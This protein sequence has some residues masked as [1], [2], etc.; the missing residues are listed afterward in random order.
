MDFPHLRQNLIKLCFVNALSFVAVVFFAAQTA[1]AAVLNVP[2]ARFATVQSAVD[3]AAPGD[4]IVLQAGVTFNESIV[5]RY[6]TGSDYITIQSSAINALPP[7]GHRVNP[8]FAPLMP[9]IK[10][11]GYGSAAM[12]TEITPNGASHHYRLI[13]LELAQNDANQMT[14]GLLLLG[15]GGS[16]QDT[17]DKVAHDFEVDRCYIHGNT[18]GEVRRGVALNS[19]HT[20]ITNSYIVDVHQVGYDTQA[21]CGWNGPGDYKIINNYLEGAAENIMFGG[22]DSPIPNL[23]PSDIVV[24]HNYL[25]K[26]LAWRD[27]ARKWTTKNLFELKNARRVT[28]D[29]NVFENDWGYA[30]GG[31]QNGTGILFTVRND[32]GR[33][34]WSAVQDVTFTNNIVRRVGTGI[35]I[36][37]SD[38]GHQS[39]TTKN[40]VIDNNLFD[41]IGDDAVKGNGDVLQLT[42]GET[43][44]RAAQNVTFTNNTAIHK[45]MLVRAEDGT[46]IINFRIEGNIAKEHILKE[47]T[48][49]VEAL[50]RIGGD[51]WTFNKNAMY[52]S[53]GYGYWST[54]YPNAGAN[55]NKYLTSA[56]DFGFVNQAA[57]NFRVAPTSALR[58]QGLNGKDVGADFHRF[59][60]ALTASDF[61]SDGKTDAVVWRPQD[62]VWYSAMSGD[63]ATVRA[64]QFGMAGDIPVAADYD[65]DGQTD[66]AVFRPSTGVW[67]IWQSGD[68]KMRS[69][70]FGLSGDVPTVGDFDGDG[71]ADIAVF[72]A[73]KGTAG[74]W[75]VWQSS[76]NSMTV[77]QWGIGGDVPAVGDFDG[78]GKTDVAV[79]R[80]SNGSWYIVNSFDNR[81]SAFQFGANGDIPTVGDYNGDGR[82]EIAVWRPAN[83]TW[84]TRRA[85]GNFDALQWGANGDVPTMGDFD[86]DGKTDQAVFRPS[87]GN[88][89]IVNSRTGTTTATNFGHV[90]DKPAVSA[91]Q[92]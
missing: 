5:L 79:F 41:A 86:G 78:D 34:P 89:Y 90:G 65:G 11:V 63:K 92:F 27:R 8:S 85:D 75:Y 32:E 71:K 15:S 22:S 40:I 24:R 43:P 10:P 6:K 19:F 33:A 84:Y 9:K 57:G 64:F 29:R 18:E 14:Y 88:W 81:I 31:S 23:V 26:P 91:A 13:G 58:N 55:Q 4:T 7:A 2:S 54:Q 47:G 30:L 20:S 60:A 77:K 59:N 61:D 39:E 48:A 72:R 53:A 51:S 35:N 76:T 52:I 49:G 25:Y 56:G 73:S 62:G 44:E 16:D 37:G 83:G 46:K 80:P 17:L 42:G 68:S 21:I 28:I 50:N 82:A 66:Y 87:N 69:Q 70:Q 74:Y 36:L 67:Y 45:G 3:A 1:D 38:D 12:A